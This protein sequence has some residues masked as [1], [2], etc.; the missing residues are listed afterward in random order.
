M[1]DE[2]ALRFAERLARSCSQALGKGVAGT[3]LHGS[4]TLGDYIP[5][6]SDVDLLVVVEDPLT[7]ARI[8]AVASAVAGQ[9]P[10]PPGRVDLRAVTRSVAAAPTPAPWMELY[11]ELDSRLETGMQV[12]AHRPERDLVV[13]LSACRAHGRS[14]LGADPSALIGEVPP[15]WVVGVGEHQL[16]VWQKRPFDSRHAELIVLTTCRIWRFAEE[17]RHCSKS[18]AGE[19][20]LGREPALKAVQ[21]ALHQRRVDPMSPIHRKPVRELLALAWA[22]LADSSRQVKE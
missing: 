13:E 12:E 6:R 10:P 8:R 18:E 19:W 21:E 1:S 5:G 2:D 16:A 17:H 14:L 20:A 11:V 22:R 9:Q 7:D 15:E 4:L 3:I